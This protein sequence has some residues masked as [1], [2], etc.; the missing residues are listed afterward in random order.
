MGRT[1]AE[2]RILWPPDA[3]SQLI[4]IDPDAGKDWRREERGMTE[5]E[6]A[7]WHHW[8][9]WVWANCKKW[10]G[11]GNPGVAV[12]HVVAKSLTQLNDQTTTTLKYMIASNSVTEVAQ[13]RI[14]NYQLL[15][16]WKTTEALLGLAES[17]IYLAVIMIRDAP[18]EVSLASSLAAIQNANLATPWMQSAR[19]LTSTQLEFPILAP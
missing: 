15:E 16:S 14:K 12:V 9:T 1:D 19:V 3:K 5:D 2:A 8:W 10:W 18:G 7:G 17:K 13:N 4:E 6:M 11:T